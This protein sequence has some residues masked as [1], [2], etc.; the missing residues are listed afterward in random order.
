MK[1][2]E[3]TEELRFGGFEV[4]ETNVGY[5]V[6]NVNND[7]VGYVNKDKRYQ[8]DTNFT[9]FKELGEKDSFLVYTTLNNLAMTPPLNRLDDTLYYV[10]F[11]GYDGGECLVQN[12]ESGYLFIGHKTDST[13]MYKT[14]FTK[15]EINDI[16]P[17][18]LAFAFKCEDN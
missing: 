2:T 1:Y 11:I 18:Y 7:C 17:D 4:S 12:V 6:Y 9:S 14:K 5:H 13:T 10:D 8:Q 3:A 16:N 15:A